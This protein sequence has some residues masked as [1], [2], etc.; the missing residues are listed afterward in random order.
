LIGLNHIYIARMVIDTI[1]INLISQEP[2]V[3]V[4]GLAVL[5]K[6]LSVGYNTQ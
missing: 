2:E 6:L 3:Y 4:K 1:G 5:C